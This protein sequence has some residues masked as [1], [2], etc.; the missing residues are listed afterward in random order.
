MS[1]LKKI[2][3]KDPKTIRKYFDRTGLIIG[4]IK[5]QSEPI[6]AIIDATFFGRTQGILIC[7]ANSKN[8]FWK[9]IATE[10]I[11]E[12]ENLLDDLVAC[13]IVF[14]AFVIDGRRGV[15][16]L[17]LRKFPDVPIQLCHFHQMQIITRYLSRR[18]KLEAGK[19]LRQIALKLSK[20]DKQSFLTKLQTWHDQWQIFLDEKTIEIGSK[21]WHY[22]HGRLRSAYRS[23][24]TN[25]P[26]LFTYQDF[27]ALK[28]PNTTNS[29]DGSFAHWKNKVKL[30]RG[31]RQ[32]R[33]IKMINFLL[34]NS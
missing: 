4:E 1:E 23:L 25:L 12:Y 30:H 31:L 24:E 8:L 27:P 9:M 20:I 11:S 34:E 18:P 33:K 3:D 29:C 14:S 7:R 10:K 16:Q 19:E 22:R 5:P 28:I 21:R 2:Y 6:K 32:D 26:W 13:S 15:L 17:L